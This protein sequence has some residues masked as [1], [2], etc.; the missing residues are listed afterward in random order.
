MKRPLGRYDYI[1]STSIVYLLRFLVTI[2][3][4]YGVMGTPALAQTMECSASFESIPDS[5]VEIQTSSDSP[6]TMVNKEVEVSFREANG[7]ILAVLRHHVQLKVFDAS[8]P[9]AS[10]VSI[11]YYREND[12]EQVSAIRGCTHLSPDEHIRLQDEA[13]KTIELNTRTNVKEFAMPAVED[14][15]VLEYSYVIQRRFIEQLP[16]FYFSHEVPTERASITITYPQYLRYEGIIENYDR[17]VSHSVSYKDTSSIP[18]VFNFPRPD[19]VITEQWTA[20]DVPAIKKEPFTSSLNDY[21]G[22]IK[23]ILSNFGLPRQDLETNW[24]VVVAKLRRNTNPLSQSKHYKLARSIGDSIASPKPAASD[25]ELQNHIYR[26]VNERVA[27]NE[28]YA[29]FSTMSD[30]AVLAGK[31][32]DQAAIN[33]TLLAMLRGADIEAYPALTATRSAGEINRDFPS[34]YQIN[35][36]VIHSI[37]A[38]HTFWMDASYPYSQPNM[39][40][41]EVNNGRS[42]LLKDSSY[43]WKSIE[44]PKS[45]FG[46]RVVAEARLY[47][48]G[49]LEGTVKTRQKGYPVQQIRQ[50]RADGQSDLA[51]LRQTLFKDYSNMQMKNVRIKNI[52]SYKQPADIKVDFTI[53][54]YAINVADGWQFPPMMIGYLRENPFDKD[55]TLPVTLDAPEQLELS[56]NIQL[57]NGATVAKTPSKRQLSI[58]GAEMTEHYRA[59]D[60]SLDYQFNI[61]IT[62]Q[63]FSLD[64]YPKLFK[65]YEHWVELSNQTWHI[66]R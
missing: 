18:K 47:R 60:Q 48:D 39:L 42:L 17:Y 56:F 20:K 19:P 4:I 10:L 34:Y 26:Y 62:G 36:L 25:R 65:L 14:G 6:Y 54:N 9:E 38:D 29:P 30:S 64:E 45:I 28:S 23:F 24:A 1:I 35:A 12:M 32:S 21:R 49:R 44:A 61:N 53:D 27:F 5:L 46:I 41:K 50:K 37:I 11:P 16:D 33:Q 66:L 31:P 55:R 40:G 3:F 51:I 43:T 52:N 8:V 15:A 13:I 59:G 57:P 7:G 22:K 58:S 2:I 63:K